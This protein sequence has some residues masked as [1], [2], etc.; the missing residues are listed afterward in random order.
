M[1]L[2]LPAILIAAGLGLASSAAAQVQID[3]SSPESTIASLAELHESWTLI[4]FTEFLRAALMAQLPEEIEY[5]A[6]WQEGQNRWEFL[7]DTMAI[8]AGL[9]IEQPLVHERD[10][11]ALDVATAAAWL[12]Q[13]LSRVLQNRTIRRWWGWAAIGNEAS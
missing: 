7:E 5:P 9:S 2:P 10:P 12:Q 11:F 13:S 1:R 6:S 4:Q 8:W 3:T